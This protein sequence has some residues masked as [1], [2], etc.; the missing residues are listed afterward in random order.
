MV[1]RP[2]FSILIAEHRQRGF[3]ES[4]LQSAVSQSF[5]TADFEVIVNR[6]FRDQNSEAVLQSRGAKLIFHSN[7]HRGE[8]MAELI[9]ASSGDILCFLDDDDLFVKQKLET[10][11]K[12]FAKAND[13]GL[14]HNQRKYIDLNGIATEKSRFEHDIDYLL[15]QTAGFQLDASRI[16]EVVRRHP[17]LAP[18][19]NSSSISIRRSVVVPYLKYLEGC[20]GA[21][22]TFLFYCALICG[23]QIAVIPDILTEYRV[24]TASTIHDPAY[25]QQMLNGYT[26]ILRMCKLEGNLAIAESAQARLSLFQLYK[27]L[28]SVPLPRSDALGQW[29]EYLKFLGKFPPGKRSWGRLLFFGVPLLVLTGPQFLHRTQLTSSIEI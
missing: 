11:Y 6:G 14:V 18:D 22:D 12:I 10:I 24:H 8:H 2:V 15:R 1:H 19:F 21:V 13:I 9:R 29:L 20:E 23:R 26:E 16:L 17:F 3:G 4:A 7:N 5:D 27:S 25:L 28:K